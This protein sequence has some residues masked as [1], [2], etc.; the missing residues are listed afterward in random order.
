MTSRCIKKNPTRKISILKKKTFAKIQEKSRHCRS[1]SLESCLD[2][3][4]PRR[5]FPPSR[6]REHAYAYTLH[7]CTRG[8]GTCAVAR[9]SREQ[10]NAPP[11]KISSRMQAAMCI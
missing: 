11:D 6:A 9:R 10:G 8:D 4:S 5:I 2:K 1:F 3:I 7:A